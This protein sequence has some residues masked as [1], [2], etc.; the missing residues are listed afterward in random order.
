M[1]EALV[2]VA[3]MKAMPTDH[4]EISDANAT[5]SSS[6]RAPTRATSCCG[7]RSRT[8]TDF[9]A[10]L[11]KNARRWDEPMN[12]QPIHRAVAHLAVNNSYELVVFRRSR[13]RF[14][15]HGRPGFAVNLLTDEYD[16]SSS[17]RFSL[18]F[19]GP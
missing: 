4:R 7:S 12:P 13:L 3:T 11:E 2:R 10:W 15:G 8:E 14:V 16:F 19:S 9:A 5:P 18:I 17:L 6:G 1:F